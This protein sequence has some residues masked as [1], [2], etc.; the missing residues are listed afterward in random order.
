MTSTETA[1]KTAAPSFDFADATLPAVKR[2]VETAGPNPFADVLKLSNEQGKGK[3]VVVP[4]AQVGTVI[5]YIRRAA[6]DQNI[7]A[8]IVLVTAD[9]SAAK[10][11]TET[12]GG[13]KTA[14]GRT[15]GGETVVTKNGTRYNGNVRVLFQGQKRKERKT[16]ATPAAANG[17]APTAPAAQ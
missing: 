9:K 8:R 7:G 12:V 5:R 17:A 13:T 11:D 4:A 2:G 15:S 16:T 6:N 1:A 14:K 3:A 10:L